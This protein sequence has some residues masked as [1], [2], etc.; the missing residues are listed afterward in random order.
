MIAH[1]ATAGTGADSQIQPATVIQRT[2]VQ[3]PEGQAQPALAQPDSAELGRLTL[4]SA[5]AVL[6]SGR[7]LV[8]DYIMGDDNRLLQI[9][10]IDP[11]THQVVAESPPSTIARM[12]QEVL[13]YQDLGS[14]NHHSSERTTVEE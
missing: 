13:T 1:K 14:R 4:P 8:A 5:Q 7:N 2:T 12:Q 11:V 9:R 3:Q 6:S 10:M